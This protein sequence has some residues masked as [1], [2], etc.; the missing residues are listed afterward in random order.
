LNKKITALDVKRSFKKNKKEGFIIECIIRP[1]GV[2]IT[3]FFYNCGFSA[4]AV[5]YLNGIVTLCTLLLLAL[6]SEQAIIIMILFYI[7]YILDVVDGNISRLDNSSSYWGKFIDGLV[8]N[9][10]LLLIPFAVGIGVHMKGGNINHS[11][12]L[13]SISIIS[14]FTH[15]VRARYSFFREWLQS[16]TGNNVIKS[17]RLDHIEALSLNLLVSCTFFSIAIFYTL[18][19]KVYILVVV[20][21][22]LLPETIVLIVNVVKARKTLNIYRKSVSKNDQ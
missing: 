6:N 9:V 7:R 14:C 18:G 5:T 8:D 13:I 11:I 3:P 17:E 2:F 21:T 4:N 19:I 10:G 16:T 20:L 22:Q 12:L 1:I 15:M